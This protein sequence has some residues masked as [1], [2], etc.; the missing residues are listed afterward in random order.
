M[1][2]TYTNMY[3]YIYIYIFIFKRAPSGRDPRLC[4]KVIQSTT[5]NIIKFVYETNNTFV[6]YKFEKHLWALKQRPNKNI[7]ERNVYM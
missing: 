5:L 3:I 1:Y 6:T 7:N 2:V 4:G